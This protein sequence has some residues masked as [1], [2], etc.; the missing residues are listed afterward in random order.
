MEIASLCS[1]S[2]ARHNLYSNSCTITRHSYDM[3]IGW[4]IPCFC[5]GLYFT[6]YILQGDLCKPSSCWVFWAASG[7]YSSECI[8][9]G[10]VEV[11]KRI[12]MPTSPVV[13]ICTIVTTFSKLYLTWRLSQNQNTYGY[14]LLFSWLQKTWPCTK[15]GERVSAKVIALPLPELYFQ[16]HSPQRKRKATYSFNFKWKLRFYFTFLCLF[17]QEK[18]LERPAALQ[19]Y[20][21]HPELFWK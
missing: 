21:I 6:K 15:S 4:E 16:E 13:N 5:P 19:T 7:C 1:S 3:V 2:G 10:Q 20:K 8:Q 14:G 12:K 11:K 9:A 18:K 17:C